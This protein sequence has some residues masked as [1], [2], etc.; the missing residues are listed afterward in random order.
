MAGRCL[1]LVTADRM[2]EPV[3]GEQYLAKHR[4]TIR[5]EG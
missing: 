3:V 2:L 4:T 1:D 5:L